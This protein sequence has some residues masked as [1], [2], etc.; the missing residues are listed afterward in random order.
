MNKARFACAF[1]L[2]LVVCSALALAPN[3]ASA[4]PGR[5]GTD[6]SGF[7]HPPSGEVP[8]IYDDHHVYAR[9]DVVRRDRVLAALIKNGQILVPL[10][11]MFE[12]I[13]A[14][15]SFDPA[16]KTVTATKGGTQVQVTLG[17]ALVKING[18]IRP[19]DV[20]PEMY[21]GTLLV[22]IRVI[23][24]ALGAYV[25]W[26]PSRRI[27]IVRYFPPTPPPVPVAPPTATPA[28]VPVVIPTATP[29]P[30]PVVPGYVGFIQGALTVGGKD[31]NEFGN[32]KYCRNGSFVVSGA[33][34]FSPHWALKF[35]S[36]QDRYVTASNGTDQF[37]NQLTV[38]STI[39]GGTA[40]TPVFLA[41]QN[42]IDARL[43]YQIGAPDWYGGIG[44][45]RASNNYGYPKLSGLGVGVEKLPDFT[46]SLSLYGSAFYY[47]SASGDY[48]VSDGA[49][50]NF[51]TTYRQ[52]YS[53]LTYDFG[54][55]WQF[56]P[57]APVYAYGGFAGDRYG[58]KQNAPIDQTHSGLY[59]GLGLKL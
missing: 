18:E 40:S 56:S 57:G 33:Y 49:S 7:G 41:S 32:G 31:Y 28:P 1:L 58:K 13:G 39:D 9:P 6:A 11:S 16:S 30:M 51:R 4:S 42:T 59:V 25:E 20:P 27:V 5:N 48:T 50:T 22:P 54:A 17:R 29:T 38:F 53:I 12:Q 2:A 55:A 47:P 24:E 8:I 21:R 23:S 35:D 46:G 45:I 19:L 14:R 15:V 34:K 37:G 10:R 43:E 44:L 36:R 3:G 52:E 26:L